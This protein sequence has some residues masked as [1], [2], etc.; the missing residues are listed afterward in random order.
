M[1]V[2]AA[3]MS[4]ARDP[5]HVISADRILY[6]QRIQFRAESNPGQAAAG[7]VMGIEP[8]APLHH[9]QLGMGLQKVHQVPAGPG[10]L[11]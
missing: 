5:G 4:A 6:R 8:P 11:Q 2:V 7:T 9:F 1:A 3:L 10:F